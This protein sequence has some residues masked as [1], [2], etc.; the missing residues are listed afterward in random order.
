MA[1]TLSLH[2]A[3]PI[4]P[5]LEDLWLEAVRVNLPGTRSSERPNWQRPMRLLLDEI[6]A[7]PKIAALLGRL[8]QA[9]RP[10]SPLTPDL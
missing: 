8:A 6:V 9:R 5:W 10:A 4:L 1:N 2:D 7:D 3:L